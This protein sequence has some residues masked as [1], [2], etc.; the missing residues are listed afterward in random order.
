MKAEISFSSKRY[1]FTCLQLVMRC[2]FGY[3]WYVLVG[4]Y[5]RIHRIV[6]AVIHDSSLHNILCCN[7]DIVLSTQDHFYYH[8]SYIWWFDDRQNKTTRKI[9][10]PSYI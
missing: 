5:E 4:D 9:E 8:Y 2:K 7:G 3:V 1:I 10:I 6:F